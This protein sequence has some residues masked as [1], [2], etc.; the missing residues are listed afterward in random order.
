[1]SL[2]PSR[3][4]FAHF[5][6]PE[7]TCKVFSSAQLHSRP[8]L[9][10]LSQVAEMCLHEFVQREERV[11]MHQSTSTCQ[12]SHVPLTALLHLPSP[13]AYHARLITPKWKGGV[14]HSVE[15]IEL[16]FRYSEEERRWRVAR[17][18]D[19]DSGWRAVNLHTEDVPQW[20][21][22]LNLWYLSVPR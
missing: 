20:S 10:S 21:S 15:Y 4:C 3:V 6:E 17:I 1:M 13:L 9:P 16:E 2:T 14:H 11:T 7:L 12:A 22:T 8:P 19:L 5:D 18:G